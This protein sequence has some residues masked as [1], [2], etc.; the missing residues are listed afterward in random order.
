MYTVLHWH[1]NV[2]QVRWVVDTLTLPAGSESG[3]SASLQIFQHCSVSYRYQAAALAKMA[4]HH[5]CYISRL[6]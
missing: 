6:R 4:S 1:C 2:L 3:R 5:N